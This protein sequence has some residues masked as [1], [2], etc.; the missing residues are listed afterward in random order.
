MRNKI[1]CLGTG[2][3]DAPIPEQIKLIRNAGF[4]ATFFNWGNQISVGEFAKITNEENMIFQSVHAPFYKMAEIW[5]EDDAAAK[6]CVDELTACLEDCIRA[7]VPIMVLHAFIGFNDHTPTEIGLERIENLVK[8]A[9]G[10]GVRLAFENTEGIEYLDAI[11]ERFTD[12][13]TVGFCWD[14]GH[15]NCYN[16][17]IDLLEKY[18][19]RLIATHLNDNLGIKDLGGKITFLDDLHLLPFDGIVDWDAAAKKLH[20]ISYDGILTFEL[21]TKSHEGRHDNDKYQLMPLENYFAECYAR[22][23]RVASKI[24]A[25]KK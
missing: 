2:G 11:L 12:K 9:E 18:G 14:S 25:Q 7:E 1:L 17:D 6:P 20:D 10:S 15:Q 24:L 5:K 4:E 3:F 23:C 8:K 21:T 19:D 16:A 22:A 13:K